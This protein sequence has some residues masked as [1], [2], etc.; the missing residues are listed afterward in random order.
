VIAEIQLEMPVVARDSEH[1]KD[2]AFR[3]IRDEL[4]NSFLSTDANL[5]PIP[6]GEKD[7][8]PGDFDGCQPWTDQHHEDNTQEENDLLDKRDCNAWM[9]K[10]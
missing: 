2:I 3:H 8:M 1:A 9:V 6:L 4:D 7:P 5:T 10:A